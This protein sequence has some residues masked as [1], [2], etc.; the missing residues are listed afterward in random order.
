MSARPRRVRAAPAPPAAA[1][2]RGWTF[3]SNH[4]HVLIC[5]ATEPDLVLRE[6]ARR[7][8]ITERAVS[9]ILGDLEAEGLVTRSRVGRRNH[10]DLHL[11]VP[12]RHPLEAHRSVRELIRLVRRPRKS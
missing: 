12:L 7:V 2:A 5:L 8:G 6:V 3:L 9:K 4:A 10:Y 11:D 1:A